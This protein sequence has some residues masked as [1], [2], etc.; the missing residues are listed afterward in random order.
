MHRWGKGNWTDER[1]RK[2][3]ALHRQRMGTPKG[4]RR[5]YGSF[6]PEAVA[7]LVNPLLKEVSRKEGR[8]RAEA[9]ACTIQKMNGPEVEQWAADFIRERQRRYQSLEYQVEVN[10]KRRQ[11]CAKRMGTE[12]TAQKMLEGATADDAM[13]LLDEGLSPEQAGAALKINP[14]EIRLLARKTGRLS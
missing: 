13:M 12:Y 7:D 6:L 14:S 5:V 11:S 8:D 4:C 1:K 9:V 10:E 2:M 3:S